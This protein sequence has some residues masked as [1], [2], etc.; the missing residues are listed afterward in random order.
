MSREVEN[1]L[2]DVSGQLT[3]GG[4]GNAYT[5][6]TARPLRAYNQGFWVRAK[7]NHTNTGA[8]TLNVREIGARDIK[9][10]KGNDLE[11][12]AI[13]DGGIYDFVDD[14]SQ[15]LLL[16]ATAGAGGAPGSIGF[17]IDGGGSVLT[18]GSKGS[19]RVPYS[20]EITSG[21]LLADQSGSIV[22]DIW[23]DS[24]GNYPPTNADSI[25]ASAPLSLSSAQSSSDTTLT[26]WTTSLSAGDIL[27]FNVDSVSSIR[28]V[29]ISL[30]TI[31]T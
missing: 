5:V 19:L 29:E 8:A 15:F 20:A 23:K 2:F 7:A 16:G 21:Y 3:L 18:T 14:G 30:D 26:G 24:I 12:G 31:K 4:S 1:L 17:T 9:D 6:R 25:T 27:Y 11:P 13:V 10:L 28:R 22:V